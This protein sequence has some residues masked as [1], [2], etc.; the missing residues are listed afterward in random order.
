MTSFR[1]LWL[2]VNSFLPR[3]S[4]SWGSG[5]LTGIVI[6]TLSHDFHLK[7]QLPPNE[8][9]KWAAARVTVAMTQQG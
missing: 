9:G 2:L 6:L 4:E 3:A 1:G 8:Q 5:I 7:R